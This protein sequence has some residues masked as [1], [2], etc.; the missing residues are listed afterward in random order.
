M[1]REERMV[2]LETRR[3]LA[4]GFRRLPPHPHADVVVQVLPD[5]QAG[6]GPD[7]AAEQDRGRAIRARSEDD[8]LRVQVAGRGRRADR[9]VAVEENSVDERVGPDRQVRP[10]SRGIEVGEGC[11]P[12]DLPD[13]VQRVEDRIVAGGLGERGLGGRDLLRRLATGPELPL[14]APQVGSS[15]AWDQPSPH[16]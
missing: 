5:G 10:L 7:A 12:P 9:P 15:S 3:L 1:T 16:S 2:G 11:V 6:F 4:Q 14:G 8:P 13:G